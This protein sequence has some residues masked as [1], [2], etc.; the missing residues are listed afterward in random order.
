[1][2]EVNK[3]DTEDDYIHV[4]FRDPDQFDEIRMPDWAEDP[5]QS[6]SEGS[7]VRMGQEEGSDNWKV[8]SLL[9]QKNVGEDKAEEQTQEIVDKIE[10]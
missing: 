3:V 1:M 9:I 2:V 5:A 4:R 8:E 6:V 10:S 7:K